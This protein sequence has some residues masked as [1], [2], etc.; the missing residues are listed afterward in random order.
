MSQLTTLQHLVPFLLDNVRHLIFGMKRK[1]QPKSSG[2]EH[3][4]AD[5]FLPSPSPRSKLGQGTKMAPFFRP[6]PWSDINHVYSFI[7]FIDL[8]KRTP[9]LPSRE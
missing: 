5:E 1:S 6:V 3:Y 9:R 8:G 7:P 2:I 4:R